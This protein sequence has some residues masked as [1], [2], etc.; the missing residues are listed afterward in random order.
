MPVMTGAAGARNR[1]AVD[2]V[3]TASPA[4]LVTMLYDRLVRDLVGAEQALSDRQL[5]PA[6]EQLLHAQEILLLLRSSLDRDAWDGADGLS[7]LYDFLLGELVAA[8]VTKDPAV[9][10]SCRILLEPL[11]DAWHAAAN[12]IGSAA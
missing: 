1:Y 2:A 3:T 12:S 7:Q 10:R 4:R 6:G 11:R 5:G 8:N 9:V